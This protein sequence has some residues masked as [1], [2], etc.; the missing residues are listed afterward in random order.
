[1]TIRCLD[2]SV[3]NPKARVIVTAD[4]RIGFMRKTMGPSF[5]RF[6][7][8]EVAIFAMTACLLQVHLDEMSN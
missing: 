3:S 7:Y 8:L 6:V 2:E 4:R 5:S 1:M